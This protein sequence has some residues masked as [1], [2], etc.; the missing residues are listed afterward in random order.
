[1]FKTTAL[2]VTFLCGMIGSA[3]A[4]EQYLDET[5]YAVSGY[6]VVSYFDLPQSDVGAPQRAPLE[7]NSQFI[8]EFNGANFAFATE[9]NRERFLADPTAFTPQYDGHC[10]YGVTKGNKVPGN[11]ML[12]RIVD[13]KLYLNITT[14]VV[15]L[16][17]DNIARNLADSENNWARLEP[18]KASSDAIPSFASEAP[19]VD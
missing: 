17:E 7:G 12:W 11:P 16:W 4:G 14:S 9:A 18:R 2:A 8:V 10:A 19:V 1:M 6:D 3:Y 13:D 5:G 15:E